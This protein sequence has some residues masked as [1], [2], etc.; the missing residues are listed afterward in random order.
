MICKVAGWIVSPRKSRRKSRVLFQ[1][2]HGDPG[3]GQQ[4]AEHDPGRP[5]PA[6]QQVTRC[7]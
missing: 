2:Q 3:T 6:M 1:D 4:Q 5:P 7:I